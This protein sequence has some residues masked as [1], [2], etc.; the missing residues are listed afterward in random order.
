MGNI[1]LKR[2]A[3]AE[4]MNPLMPVNL[5]AEQRV[6][7]GKL[8]MTAAGGFEEDEAW[9][10]KRESLYEFLWKWTGRSARLA[11]VAGLGTLFCFAVSNV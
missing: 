6:Q 2:K 11:F 3:E 9:A 4:A 5:T 8:L 10:G 7:F 1:K